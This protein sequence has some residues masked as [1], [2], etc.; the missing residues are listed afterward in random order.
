ME[1]VEGLKK[2]LTTKHICF[3]SEI[4]LGEKQRTAD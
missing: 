3:W 1:G 4:S 2:E